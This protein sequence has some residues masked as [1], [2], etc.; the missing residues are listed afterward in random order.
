[1]QVGFKLVD[2]KPQELANVLWAA[3]SLGYHDGQLMAA[4][5]ARAASLAPLLKEQE[6][7]NVIWAMGK[8]QLS[9]QKVQLCHSI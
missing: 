3:A 6:L 1:M 5:A 2:F 4:V 7:A 8:M 9:D